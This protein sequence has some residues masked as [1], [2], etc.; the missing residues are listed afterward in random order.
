MRDFL[1]HIQPKKIDKRA[2]KFTRT[3]GLGGISLLLIIILFATGLILRFSYIPSTSEAYNSILNLQNNS[4]FGKFIRNIHY[5]S[6]QLLVVSTFLHLLRVYY[7]QS[8]YGKR[9]KNWLY[10]L[11]L[12]LFILIANFTGYI[13]PWSQLSYWAVT[14]STQIIENISILPQIFSNSS[15]DNDIFNT[16][17][18]L[19]AYNIHTGLLPL[20]LV[21]LLA[22]HFWLVRKAGGIALPAA[23]SPEMI[24]VSPYLIKFE[25]MIAAITIAFVMLMAAF[26][27]APL[28]EAANPQIIPNPLKSPWYFMGIQELLIHLNPIFS[29]IIIPILFLLFLSMSA[30]SDYSNLNMGQWFNS[31]NGQKMVILAFVFSFFYTFA[32]II[33]SEYFTNSQIYITRLPTI[34]STGFIPF[35]IFI[36]PIFSFIYV[37]K[38]IYKAAKVEVAMMI[39]SSIF[40]SYI[41]MMLICWLLRGENM[42]LIIPAFR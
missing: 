41:C 6:S 5:L 33:L 31:K 25:I 10:G 15:A 8:I 35:L 38:K 7:T 23:K 16:N 32:L 14:I 34:L 26:Y 12:F 3:F 18:L 40:A 2:I 21:F 27:D 22:I 30:Y 24:K 19:I 17:V 9:A 37:V 39:T 1:L 36:I 29:L 13:L 20:L 11:I 42:Q 28:H 4:L